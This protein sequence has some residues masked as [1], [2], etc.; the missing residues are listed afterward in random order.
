MSRT[1]DCPAYRT[2]NALSSSDLS[3]L[4]ITWTFGHSITQL[5]K[6][7]EV[8]SKYIHEMNNKIQLTIS[9]DYQRLQHVEFGQILG[10]FNSQKTKNYELHVFVCRKWTIERSLYVRDYGANL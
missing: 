5:R 10:M 4:Q 6:N 2:G 8:T 7:T 1:P 9:S 3:K